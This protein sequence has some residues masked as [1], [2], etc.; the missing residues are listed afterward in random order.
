MAPDPPHGDNGALHG[1][2]QQWAEVCFVPS[3]LSRSKKGAY[4]FLA[5]R[6]PLAA[7]LLPGM[8]EQLDLPFPEMAFGRVYSKLFG[9]VTN[10]DWDGEAMVFWPRQRA[11]SQKR[12]TRS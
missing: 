3:S 5:G 12:R 9:I 10:L 11:A 8:G 4:R 6:E 1:T 7:Q 2:S